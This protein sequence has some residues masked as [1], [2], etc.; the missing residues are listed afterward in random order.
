MRA[1][2]VFGFGPPSALEWSEV[3]DPQAGRGEVVV[4]V[5]A[6]GVNRADALFRAG[7][8]H[9]GPALP[10]TPGL[11]GAGRVIAVG[12]G[13]DGVREGDRVLAWGAIG[14]PGFYAER[15]AVP[16]AR[17]LPVPAAV[18]LSAA[19]ALPVAWLTA[20]YCLRRLG[21]VRRGD[22]VLVHAGAGGVGSAA[23]QIAK[24][25]GARVIATAGGEEKLKWVRDL[26]ADVVLDHTTTDVPAEVLRLTGGRGA[27]VVLDLVGGETF[28]GS[29]RSAARAANVVALANVALAPSV[30]DTRD[31]YPKNVHIHGF[32]IT[33]LMEHGFDPRS[34]L[35][36]LLAGLAE[37][38]FAVPIDSTYPLS[39][40]AAAHARLESRAVLGKVLL[41]ATE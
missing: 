17:V 30:I 1:S 37:R 13:V 28:A 21:A 31:F 33:D 24:A 15:V 4:E 40:A 3:P 41:I 10:A 35:E 14:D 39:D 23:V 22:D 26:G 18:E 29:L 27:D 2:R 6:A 5:A 7:R 20:W 12:D 19:A 38:R 34:D 25:A 11:E 16:V 8:Y 32:Q 9:R 36:D